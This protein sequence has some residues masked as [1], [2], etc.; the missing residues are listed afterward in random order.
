MGYTNHVS[1][2][3]IRNKKMF[4]RTIESTIKEK[5]YLFFDTD[6]PCKKKR[7]CFA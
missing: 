5:N 4:D 2:I 3:E 7:L 1:K 6:Y